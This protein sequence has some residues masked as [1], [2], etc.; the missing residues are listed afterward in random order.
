MI[1]CLNS[2]SWKKQLSSTLGG[3]DPTPAGSGSPIL[4]GKNSSWMT[5]TLECLSPFLLFALQKTSYLSGVISS[6]SCWPGPC[7]GNGC[8]NRKYKIRN[9]AGEGRRRA[10]HRHFM[11]QGQDQSVHHTGRGTL[12]PATSRGQKRRVKEQRVQNLSLLQNS[13]LRKIRRTSLLL[14]G[15]PQ[16]DC[17]PTTP[18]V[19][20]L[21]CL[22]HA[23]HT[24]PSALCLKSFWAFLAPDKRRERSV[25]ELGWENSTFNC[26][27][28]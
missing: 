22:F 24:L 1:F 19:I 25:T 9:V 12:V 14:I 20:S 23:T 7:H 5:F 10:G 16:S 21:L 11:G 17:S 2:P 6:A 13:F 8:A 3:R 15:F 26:Y 4:Q 28:C 18:G 27:I